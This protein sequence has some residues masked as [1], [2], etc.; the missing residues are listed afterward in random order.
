MSIM[1][2]KERVVLRTGTRQLAAVCGSDSASANY[3]GTGKHSGNYSPMGYWYQDG[4]LYYV[5]LAAPSQ[6]YC[7]LRP[8]TIAFKRC[9]GVRTRQ[10]L[11]EFIMAY[12]KATWPA[13]TTDVEAAKAAG[14]P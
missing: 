7:G 10:A 6:F 3:P 12:Y 2:G 9:G 4:D 14:C 5:D 13:N 8:D 11:R 1:Y